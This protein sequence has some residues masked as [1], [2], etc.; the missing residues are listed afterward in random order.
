[1]YDPIKWWLTK[2]H[3]GRFRLGSPTRRSIFDDTFLL[4]LARLSHI[5]GTECN[6]V[7]GSD[8]N[9]QRFH[10]CRLMLI[11]SS[12]EQFARHD[13]NCGTETFNASQSVFIM[14]LQ[15]VM[16]TIYTRYSY[17]DHMWYLY[18]RYDITKVSLTYFFLLKQRLFVWIYHER[19]IFKQDYFQTT[20]FFTY[21]F[22]LYFIR[23]AW[24]TICSCMLTD[25]TCWTYWGHANRPTYVCVFAIC[26]RAT[27]SREAKCLLMITWLR[28][29]LRRL[30]L[31]EL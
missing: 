24:R 15:L 8:A 17:H 31:C 3:P 1:M 27:W 12:D 5:Q 20:C 16:Y 4:K 29:N 10:K 9:Q 11:N 18:N 22:L 26:T 23:V 21:E 28:A 30:Q 19:L 14:T 25:P 6:E 7:R 2:W 13:G